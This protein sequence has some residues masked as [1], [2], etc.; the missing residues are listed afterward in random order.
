MLEMTSTLPAKAHPQVHLRASATV[1]S[2]GEHAPETDRWLAMALDEVD[3]GVLLLTADAEVLHL[4]HRA[5]QL[6]AGALALDLVGPDLRAREAR[7]VGALADA[8]RAAATRGLRKLLTLGRGEARQLAVIVPVADGVAAMLLGRSGGC[9]ALS[10]QCYA[11]AQG[12]TTAEARVLV[13]LGQGSSPAEIAV[14]QG[15]K[16]STVRTQ[17]GA[18]RGKTGAASIT[19]LVRMV[20]ALPPMMTALRN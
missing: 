15:V 5:K 11:R 16:L 8:V 1:G 14:H 12:L 7:D 13:A 2:A 17:I 20:A 18:I 3:Y 19:A 4:N 6:L 10:I 9:E